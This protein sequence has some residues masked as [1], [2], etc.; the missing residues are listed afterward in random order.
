MKTTLSAIA[1]AAA[2]ILAACTTPQSAAQDANGGARH[3][4]PAP[5]QFTVLASNAVVDVSLVQDRDWGRDDSVLLRTY[6]NDWYRVTL[7]GGCV[8]KGWGG[9]GLVTASGTLLDRGGSI[10]TSGER[11]HIATVD[12]IAEPPPNSRY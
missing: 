9:I 1:A 8:N 11:C 7:M 2:V 12:K 4:R 5:P 3:A 10:L 6:R